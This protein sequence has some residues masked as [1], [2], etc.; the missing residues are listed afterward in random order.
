MGIACGRYQRLNRV[1]TV[2]LQQW[3]WECSWGGES[4]PTQGKEGTLEVGRRTGCWT[5]LEWGGPLLR[6]QED[7][8]T[9]QNVGDQAE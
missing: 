3:G 8:N 5:R 9:M 1:K 2:Y 4:E 7:G 6:G